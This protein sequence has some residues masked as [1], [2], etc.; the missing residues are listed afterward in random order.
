MPRYVIV[1]CDACCVAD[2]SDVTFM[3]DL[4]TQET[5]RTFRA[6]LEALEDWRV[7]SGRPVHQLL[8]PLISFLRCY[9]EHFVLSA[10]VEGP[11]ITFEWTKSSRST[12]LES[13][14]ITEGFPVIRHLV[15]VLTRIDPSRMLRNTVKGGIVHMLQQLYRTMH[16]EAPR[17]SLPSIRL[18]F[19]TPSAPSNIISA[20]HVYATLCPRVGDP[21]SFCDFRDAHVSWDN[22]GEFYERSYVENT[23]LP[24][25]RTLVQTAPAPPQYDS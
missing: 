24:L 9:L 1:N 11:V 13:L 21:A 16:A 14:A 4:P 10:P 18:Q 15:C 8:R 22:L 25:Y 23:D 19:A 6:M 7:G 17:G 5:Y 3:V 2:T 20:H 12:P